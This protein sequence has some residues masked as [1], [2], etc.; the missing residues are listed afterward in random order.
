MYHYSFNEASPKSHKAKAIIATLA[1]TVMKGVV[2]MKKTTK[3]FEGFDIILG[4]I[5]LKFK[6]PVLKVTIAKVPR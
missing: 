2:L 1:K 6:K 4:I 5:V 3:W